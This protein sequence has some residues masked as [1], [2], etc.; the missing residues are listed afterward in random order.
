[1]PESE[2][3][4]VLRNLPHSTVLGL[5]DFFDAG[6][7]SYENHPLNVKF[8]APT[9]V[10]E[11]LAAGLYIIGNSNY[12]LKDSGYCDYIFFQTGE[13][14][15]FMQE[16]STLKCKEKISFDFDE[17]FQEIIHKIGISGAGW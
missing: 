15:G 2:S 16:I 4:L 5:Y 3:I 14:L 1:M 17:D 6:L 12:S 10:Y 7:L 11:Y 8:C 13:V 9:K